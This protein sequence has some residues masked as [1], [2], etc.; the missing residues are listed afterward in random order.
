M[1]TMEKLMK[2]FESLR[3]FQQQQGPAAIP[4]EPLQ[5]PKKELS[6]TKKDRVNH[7]LTICENIVAQSLRNSPEFQKL[8]GIA[9]EVFLLCSED[10]ESD[11]RMV[12]DECLNKVIKV[13]MDSSLPRLQL[14]L[15]KEI[16][17]NG[18]SRSLRAALWRFAE[19][20]H[21]VRPQKCR[22]YLVNLLPCLTRISKRPEESVQET[23]AAAIPKIMAA[24][25][26]FANDNEIKVL[27]K[28]F[29]ANLKSSSPTIRRTA[30][31]SA[32]SICQH[33]RRMQ[34]FYAWLLNVLLG[35]LVPVDDDH[36][37]LLILGVL[38][39]L[40]YLI[41]LLQQQV[42]DTSL[43]GS[44]GVTRKEAE[45]SPSPDQ[46]VQ[47]YELTLHY[48]QHQDHNV[49][50]GALELLQQLFRTPPPE[51][52]HALTATGGIAQVSVSK[53]ESTSR[54]RSGSIVELIAG[55]GSSC[56]PVLARKHKGKILLGEEEGLED[57][58]ETRS[59]VS[60]AS[61]AAS[62]KGEITSELASSS[63][64]STAGSAG[65]SAADPTGHDI[66]TEQPRSQHTLQSDSVDLTSCDLTSTATEGEDD[67]VL[68]RSSSQI[69][70]VQSDPT[71]D[72]NDGTQASSPISDSSQTTTEGPDSAVTPSDSSEIVLESAEG[73]YSGMQ[74]GQLQDEED[75]AAN[76]LQDDSSE[77]FRNS[78]IALQQ[79]HLLKTTSHSRQPSDSSVDRF[80]SKEDAADPGDHENKPSRIKGD[81]GH[82]TDGNSAPLVHC[83]RLLSA[84]F[85]LTGEKGA[86]VPDRDVRVSVKALA[87]SCVGAAV[88][89]HPESF[90]SKLY[91]TPLEAMGEEYE[92][93]YVS[94]ILNYIDHGD[95][96]IRGATAILC[97]TIIN[98]ILLK[99]RFDVE[100]WLINIR[101]STGNLFSLVDCIPLLQKMLKDESSVTCKL[102]CTA[103]RHC[104]MSLCSSSYSE[105]GLQLIV[106]L[107]TLK[108][109]SYWLV[110]TELL[111][112]LAEVDFRLVNFLE[113]KTD[114]LHRGVHH[115]TGLLK[116]QERVLNN[117]VI[118]LLGDEDPRVRHVAASSLMRLVPKLF[119]NCDQGQADPVVAVAR[120]QSGVYLKLLM[121][122]TQP[123]SHFA[124][125][126]ITRTY[127]GYNMLQSPTDVTMEN[128]LSRVVAAISHALTISTTR[129][130]TFGCCE[131]LC[132]LST[133]FPVCTWT[134]GWHCGVSQPN[135]SDEAQKGCTIGMAGMVLSLL[136]SAWFPLDLSAHQDA[137]I[138]TGNLLAASAPKCL[139]NPWSAEE[140]SNQGAAKQEEP[141]PAL[142]DRT[143]VTLVEQL[144]S[145]LLKV[146]NICAHVMDDVA[147]GP[148]VKAAL[149]SLTNP[150]SLS[151]IRR[152]G[153]EREPVEQASVPMSPKKGGETSPATRQ[154]DASG[155][156]PTSKSSSVGSFYHLPSYLKLYD[157]LKA[158]HA[159]YK[160][161]LDLQN[162]NEKFG[163]FLRSA[164]DVL[165]Q[166]LELATL[167]DI[168]KCVEEIL[169][170]L[171]SCFNREPTMATVCVQ[172]LL[173]TL[174]GTNLA[175]QYDGLSSNTSKAQGK[176]QRLGS[177]N[178]RPGLYHY[179]F[180]APYTHFTQALADASLRNMVQAE[181]EHD[182]SGWFDVL[183]KVSTQLK[184]SISS[185][186]KH[187]AD[188]NAIHNHIRLFEPLVIKALKQYTTTTSVQL[189]R[190]VLDLLAQLVQL[191]VNYC[192]LDS[193]QVF[194][195]FVL[196]QFEYI[197]VGQFRESEAII[198][199][200]FFFLVLLSYERY[201]SKQIIGIPK[202]IQLCDGIM[203]SGRK[204]VTHAIPALQ[205]IVHDLFVLRGTNKADA[206]KE[207]ETQKEVVV[208][209]LL[210]LIQYHQV[211]EMFILVLQQCHKENEDK[212]KRL[213]RQ[214][215]DIILPMLAKQQMHIDSH[216]AL[217]VLN[218]LFEILAPSSL[219]P[220]DMLLRSMFV[221][222]KTMASV[223]TVQLWIS[224][225]LAILRVLIS[226]STEDIVLSRIQELSF[227]P[228]LISCQAINRLRRGENNVSTPEDR[229]E[230]KQAKY[231]P[232]ETFSR[233]L[234]QLVGILLEDI[235]TKQLKVDMNEQQHTFYC[236]ELGTL[237]MCLIHIFKS[238]MFRRITAAA[239][240]LFTGDGS[241]GSF[242]TLE[243]LSDLVQSMIP[244]HPSLVLLWCQILLL[245]NYTNYNWWSEVHQ[246]PKRHSLSTTKLL[247]PQIC[248]DSDE[249]D[250]ESKRGMCNREIVR[251]GAL[252]LF[253]D[254][255]CQN[256]HDSEHLTWL[257]VNHV[258]DLIN[259]SHEPPVQDFISAVH[260]NSAASGLFIQAIQSRCENLAA[261]TT[262]KKTLQCLEGIHLS[263]SGAVL[264]LYVDKL[265]CTPFR[266]LARMV[267]TLACRR[268]EMLLAATLQNSITQLP[269]E[270]LD[271][272]QEYLQNSGLATRHQRLYSLLDRFRLMVAPDTT[273]PSPVVTS[274]PLD[275]EGQPALETVILD[276]DWYVS[277]VRSQCCIKSDSALLEGA[278]LVNRIP[279]PDLNSFMTCK[280]FNLSLLA[281]C[282]SLGM[283]E[284]SR[285]QKSSLF[286]T[287]RRVTLDHVSTTVLN[288]PA[289]HQVFQPLLP[290]EPSAY[291]KKLSDIFGDEV[292]YCSVMTLCRA[293][294]QYLLLLSKLPTGLRVPP[295]KEDDIL[296]FVVMSVEALSW[297]LMHDQLPLSIDLQAA[298]D[299][300]CLTLQ[301]PNLWN[302]LASAVHVTYACSLINCIRFIIEAVAVEPG[303]QLLS[304]ERKKNTSKGLNE[305]EVD[306]NTQKNKHVTAACEMVA[307]MVECLQTVLALGHQR[308]SSIP[309]FLTPVLKNII[310][311]LARLPLVNSYTRV[312]PLVWK[313]GWSPKPAGDFGT[314]FPEIPVEFLQEKEIFK[315]FIYRINTLGWISRTQFEETW[316]TLLG[317]LVTQPIVM[318]QE[319]SQQE[320]D[321]ERTQIN[322]LAVQAI[323]S[324]VLSAMTIPVAGNPAVSCLEQQPRNKALKAL[325]TRFGR[326][327]SVIRGIVEQEI[328]AMVSK[329]DNIATHHL[330]QAWDPVPSL[331]PA[332]TG[333]L[334]SH[335]KLLLQ[336]NTEREIGDMDYKLGQVSIHSIW[337]GNNI[338]PLREEE[339]GED[340]EDENDIPAPSS[341]PTSPI[342]TRKH[343]AGVDIH[344]CSQFLLELYSQWI[345]PSN[346]S[347]RTPVILIS[348]VVRSLLAV[349]DLFTERNQF[350][351][352]YTTLTELRK[353]HPSEDEI[354]VQYL[355]PATCK[356]AA[357]LG[358][359]KAVAE[360]V[361]RLL[362]STLR[363]THMPSRIGALH[364]ILYILECDLLDETAKQ[365]IPI[366]SDYL[367]S[368][369][370]GVAHC[371]NIHNQQ[372][373]LVMC[374]AA[375][376]LIEN[377]PLDV[378]PEFS[379]GIIQ[380]CG[381]M[382]SGSDESTPSIIY[383]CVLRGLER[384]LLSEQ[385]SRLDSESLVKLSVDRVNVQSPHRA[386]AALGL[387]LT[388]MYTGKEKISPSRS[389]DANPAAPDS[390]SVI[391][392][393]E[394]VSVLFDRI[395]KGFPFEARVVARI[396]PQFLDDFFPPQDVMNKVIGEFLSNQQPYPQFMA[397]VVYK[398]FQT[399]HTT[400]QS[401]MVRDWV[402][403]SL[404][405]FTQRTPVA[406]AMWSLSCFFV[407]ASTSQWISA[408]LPHI[409][410]RMGKLEQVDV[411]I[412]CLVAIDFYRHQID[413]ELDRRAFQSVFEVVASPGTPYHRLLTCL[414]NVHK[415]TAC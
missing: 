266:V 301:Q 397:T 262:L 182:A 394:R 268:V 104:I 147:P 37:T 16:K 124:V 213:S 119:Y 201:H 25:G 309:A 371:V 93:Q 406:M 207:L 404:S 376:Y 223:S 296:K 318:D 242:Y 379:A 293:L 185:A 315:E 392:A 174:F 144:F 117:V 173:K 324:L 329:R 158:T 8:L 70:A 194:I 85:L 361:S 71:M 30:A 401:S 214:I 299:C 164:L 396:L 14:E 233:F 384:L 269:V 92:E 81:I 398:V 414:Q 323:T 108:N 4:E 74:I 290:T 122:E 282:L 220:V 305:D 159:N 322:V 372:H 211:L 349:S 169:G 250:S 351:M 161:T 278:E 177:S 90:F 350:E 180:M 167:Q 137:L 343:R 304:P 19:L 49:V 399:L 56:S 197:E 9:M 366:I 275:G 391:V 378:G 76:I 360:P 31:G 195:G 312:P 109:S 225:I 285:D 230:V 134:V 363:S 64:V 39:T 190:Q 176:A 261:P 125:S 59:D 65:S 38:L 319:E 149:P 332:T 215:A 209:M 231:L 247:S 186:A 98:S 297:R 245:V 369:L 26:N 264:T 44:F 389:T 402:M 241:D 227:S 300:C 97:G 330:Y 331:S 115:Y 53:D 292:M 357:V 407:S 362:E 183:Q 254:Y 130:L 20:A 393:M 368:N 251:R 248:G 272:I 243:S 259:L 338:T 202:I 94:D 206:G 12:A 288:L 178:L 27:L 210:R 84:S 412:F 400:G 21:L 168:G 67:D 3:S 365:L 271:R 171:K 63:G 15:Y 314:V 138:L 193:D 283:N 153:K 313:L 156:V 298:L 86:L 47:V 111:E 352:M 155:P 415:V 316:A 89:L 235:V 141:W 310:I 35:L 17:K 411:N 258:Q 410:S 80:T 106:D 358:M 281:P 82:Y 339:W 385:L 45:I 307:E 236:Q 370:R 244:T 126:T 61:F 199:N 112:T 359:D 68:S 287:A 69:S 52:L 203:A 184:T 102:A 198:P 103:V 75:E 166:I 162:S 294:A 390:E 188:K 142:A 50:T 364:G 367:L 95:P 160:V 355:I 224:G 88:A 218:T 320:E 273:S 121:H 238:G 222:P 340:E 113:G 132:L 42:K 128:N 246:T 116:L 40:R 2:A 165:S 291:W 387:M 163:C 192:L 405:N 129:A 148:A 181:Q 62:V 36:P 295:D 123:P 388:C 232:E 237:L 101:S 408:I 409:I 154:S 107:L 32:V 100:K 374:A 263:Q 386:M 1:A 325:D 57:D 105:L 136:S 249:S 336:I 7:C 380:M 334:I 77:S 114:S 46:L 317:V 78:S 219:R 51:L 337:L 204:A 306:S 333:A 348:E 217:G 234:L 13:L 327:L 189:Q 216:D 60:A 24:F 413:E 335:E 175:S 48:T 157:V 284:I 311:S 382:V 133:T 143:L 139:K 135:P 252:I 172:Q 257:I 87:V 341:P 54:N 6:T 342:N 373:I 302:L 58:S 353:V 170:Y 308:N 34:Y 99:S 110:R 96:Q 347:K 346:P 344:S 10:A 179:C 18:A 127:R 356:A 381:V 403:L 277:L 328:Q 11:V 267:D 208:S 150:P 33:S 239:T 226:Q 145:H 212:W 395:R 131:A 5:R 256:L 280:E 286:E 29:I 274:H 91:K 303:N 377:Y 270:E 229:A 72:L 187:R 55:G 205:P 146:I 383:H 253:C 228:Y 321:T 151:P 345:L 375:F 326:K 279:Q 41:P 265:L 66:I 43:K 23:L 200:I 260:R 191:R 140:D 221:T 22:P 196:K 276:K 83:V 152:K 118:S 354:L 79:P 240:R 120:D 255:V 289:N 28:A 73:Q